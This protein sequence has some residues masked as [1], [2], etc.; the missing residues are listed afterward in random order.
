MTQGNVT[1]Y[2]RYTF[3]QASVT[4][5]VRRSWSQ[6]KYQQYLLVVEKRHLSGIKHNSQVWKQ[7]CIK[8]SGRNCGTRFYTLETKTIQWKSL[9][10]EWKFKKT[11]MAQKKKIL[12]CF[13]ILFS[14][15]ESYE[16][17][18]S[19]VRFRFLLNADSFLCDY[20]IFFFQNP[21]SLILYFLRCLLLLFYHI[22]FFFLSFSSFS[23]ISRLKI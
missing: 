3:K 18:I 2:G 13:M 4:Y 15:I 17:I 10:A 8:K 6:G 20:F 1:P 14:F 11:K 7:E 23:L 16:L 12:L 5:S 9:G 19:F 21:F 22:F